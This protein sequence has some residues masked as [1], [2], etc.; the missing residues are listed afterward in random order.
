MDWYVVEYLYPNA[1]TKFKEVMFPNLGIISISTLEC[2]NIKKLYYFFDAQGV[3]LNI[4][5]Y[6]PQ[7]WFF[8]ISLNNGTVFNPTQQSKES[9]ESVE[10]EGFFECFRTLEK[11]LR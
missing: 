1:F 10:E 8:T 2:Y 5:M 11:K 3:Y 9:R 4:E 6:N 7:T